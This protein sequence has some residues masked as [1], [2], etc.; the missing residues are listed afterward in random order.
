MKIKNEK[1]KFNQQYKLA[2]IN[3]SRI[4]IQKSEEYFL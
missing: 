2:L 1:D 3:L 4:D